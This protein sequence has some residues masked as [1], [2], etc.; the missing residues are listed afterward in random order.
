MA[1]VLH[2]TCLRSPFAFGSRSVQTAALT[3]A[4][5][6]PVGPVPVRVPCLSLMIGKQALAM[7][8]CGNLEGASWSNV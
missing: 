7:P 3:A 2:V 6:P 1:H 4:R 8:L 5:L